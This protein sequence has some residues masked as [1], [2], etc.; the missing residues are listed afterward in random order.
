LL[1]LVADHGQIATQPDPHYDLSNHP[2]LARRLHILPTGENRLMYLYLRP[3]QGEAARE[4]IERT[5]PNQFVFLD[6]VFAINAGLFGPGKPH[7]R[8]RDRLGGLL[9]WRGGML[10]CGG[11]IKM[12]IFMVA[13]AA[14][15]PMRC[16]YPFWQF[17]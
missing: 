7:P 15:P 1:I 8:L 13:M 5:W 9:Y 12:I 14:C 6:P 11:R 17:D 3:G 2:S 10:T 4:Y 16:W